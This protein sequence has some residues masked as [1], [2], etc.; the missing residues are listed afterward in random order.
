MISTNPTKRPRLN[1][2]DPNLREQHLQQLHSQQLQ[3]NLQQEHNIQRQLYE[4]S[5]QQQTFPLSSENTNSLSSSTDF[6]NK[7]EET[8]NKQDLQRIEQVIDLIF[9]TNK[10]AAAKEAVPN[11][12]KSLSNLSST[13]DDDTTSVIFDLPMIVDQGIE[14]D[15]IKS[16]LGHMLNHTF[17]NSIV[18]L[19][20]KL[21]KMSINPARL[22]F[23]NPTAS[24]SLI[25]S[26]SSNNFSLAN[27]EP[28]TKELRKKLIN[29][30]F[31]K[32][33]VVIPILDR[34][35]FADKWKDKSHSSELLVNSTLAVAAARY[36]ND[37][38]IQKT[39]NKPGGVFF[40]YAKRLLDSMYDTPRLETVQSLLLLSHAEVGVSRINSGSM[41]L[42]M[43][44]QMA[45]ALHL[46]RDEISIHPEEDEEKRRVFYCI[47]CCER[48]SS[49][50]MGKP[51]SIDDIN[52]NVPLPILKSFS[53]STR[54]FFI[55]L[56]KLSRILGQIWKFGYSS[57]PKAT[58]TSWL[59]QIIDRKSMLR[60]IRSALAKWLKELPDELQYQYLPNTDPRSLIQL[61]TFSIFSGYINILFHTCIIALHQ[62]YLTSAYKNPKIE[63]QGPSGPI[64]TCLT[65]AMTLTD[66]AKTTRKY[67]REAFCNF[68]YVLYGLLQSTILE[69]DIIYE[70]QGNEASA[71]KAL[72]DSIEELRFA[73]ENSKFPSLQETVKEL[74]GVIMIVNGKSSDIVIPFPVVMQMMESRNNFENNYGNIGFYRNSNTSKFSVN[75]KLSTSPNIS[76]DDLKVKYSSS[77]GPNEY[78]A[79]RSPSQSS[80]S[81]KLNLT[82][83]PTHYLQQHASPTH[84]QQT[85]PNMYIMSSDYQD[86]TSLQFHQSQPNVSPN[87]SSQWNNSPF[88]I[89]DEIYG[90]VNSQHSIPDMSQITANS[91]E[92]NGAVID[93]L[94]DLYS[95]AMITN[96]DK[97][98]SNSDDTL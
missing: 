42:G 29:E 73:A 63:T 1:E 35:S 41:F 2:T 74:E 65:A 86:Q 36:S 68:Q 62:P 61:A 89:N 23:I 55:A 54:S 56:V 90:F 79:N 9:P 87:S 94:A 17:P 80:L 22:D 76:D 78:Q 21:N 12:L 83:P 97:N 49:F 7:H 32:F 93:N 58:H 11:I 15:Q 31:T 14:A 70:T 33:N 24:P 39:P 38:L 3:L 8:L 27:P 6:G 44:V 46:E 40:D 26:G 4:F 92:T 37:P 30:Y 45:H 13:K 72:D 60:Q 66:I 48:W 91:S 57:Q 95:P 75:E 84:K 82:S 98:N 50:S 25:K 53:F 77:P 88:F 67:D 69:L 43:A 71:K 96:S 34:R 51:S 47:Y 20:G 85:N 5:S 52:V 81:D 10:S 64:K 59:D 18:E 16:P 28:P 19:V